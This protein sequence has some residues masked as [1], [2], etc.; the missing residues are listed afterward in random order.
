MKYSILKGVL[1][2]QY[3]IYIYI[4]FFS[5]TKYTEDNWYIIEKI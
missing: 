4:T 1:F 5:L 2:F 3:Y